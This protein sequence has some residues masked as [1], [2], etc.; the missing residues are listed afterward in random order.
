MTKPNFQT[1]G[2]KLNS[3]ETETM[4]TLCKKEGIENI[5]IINTC[6]VTAEAVKKAK[7]TIRRSRR[8]NPSKKIVVTG[9]AAQIE[10]D[11]FNSMDEVNFVIGNEEKLSPATWS[12][13]FF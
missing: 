5:T 6:A 2:C 8:E 4:E 12:N 3:Y 9:C 11:T 10:P 7:K 13:N 1:F